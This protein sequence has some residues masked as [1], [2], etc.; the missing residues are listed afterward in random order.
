MKYS[1]TC[2]KTPHKKAPIYVH[3]FT[4]EIILFLKKPELW[5][6]GKEF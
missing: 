1:L 2:K 4:V 5:G 3:Q 6:E